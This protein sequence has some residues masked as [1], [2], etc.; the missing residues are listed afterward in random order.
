MSNKRGK[1]N[2]PKFRSN[3]H[4]K[5]YN[6]STKPAASGT[7]IPR[8]V[9]GG[10]WDQNGPAVVDSLGGVLDLEDPPIGGKG[11]DGEI[12]AGADAAHRASLLL[13]SLRPRI[14][15]NQ[16]SERASEK[17]RRGGFSNTIYQSWGRR[18]SCA[19]SWRKAKDVSGSK[20]NRTRPEVSKMSIR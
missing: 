16:H 10:A 7:K 9:E 11:G 14:G 8:E 3:R 18:V 4:R 19:S 13:R 20:L 6:K 5:Q 1:N 2:N 15:W 12:V 17:H